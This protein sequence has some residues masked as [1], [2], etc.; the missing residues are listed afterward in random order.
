MANIIL[1]TGKLKVYEDL[2]YLCEFTGKDQTFLDTLWEALSASDSLYEEFAYY[3]DNHSLKDEISVSGY[4]LTDLYIHMIEN[5]NLLN[6]TG[7]N[8]IR[9]NKEAMVLESFMGMWKLIQNP[10]EYIK[11]LQEGRGMDRL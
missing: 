5:Y 3:I 6:D 1:C 8:T 4:S 2:K 7:K 11:K 9:C 10:E